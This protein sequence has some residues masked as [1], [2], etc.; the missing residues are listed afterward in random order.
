MDGTV[1]KVFPQRI[2]EAIM[3]HPAVE[4]CGTIVGREDKE[5]TTVMISFV[6]TKSNSTCVSKEEILQF[7]SNKLPAYA[8]PEDI[9]FVDEIPTTQSGKI[10]YS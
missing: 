5:R 7:L 3:S 6:K 9:V 10:N 1:Y 4:L 2:E 8:M